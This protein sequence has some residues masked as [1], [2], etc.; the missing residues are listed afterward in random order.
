METSSDQ[1]ALSWV[2]FGALSRASSTTCGSTWPLRPAA[3][4]GGVTASGPHRSRAAR[5]T[6]RRRGRDDGRAPGARGA[7]R[8]ADRVSGAMRTLSSGETEGAGSL[9]ARPR[10]RRRTRRDR[11]RSV[12]GSRRAWAPHSK[13]KR[14]DLRIRFGGGSRPA[15]TRIVPDRSHKSPSTVVAGYP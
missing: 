1:M 9:I 13:Q 4:R 14:H 3:R 15:R 2:I 12:P 5:G 7:W 6:R 8:R 11:G 10:L